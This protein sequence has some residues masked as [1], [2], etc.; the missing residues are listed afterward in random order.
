MATAERDRPAI[1][2]G[3]KQEMARVR[4]AS[5]VVARNAAW[6]LWASGTIYFIGSLAD[7]VLL[8]GYQRVPNNHQFEFTALQSTIEGLP[9]FVLALALI[10]AGVHISGRHSLLL[11]RIFAV[12]LILLGIVAGVIAPLMV[13]DYFVLRGQLQPD[14]TLM[15]KTVVLKVLTLSALHVIILVPIGVFGLRRPGS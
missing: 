5:D 11:Q 2:L 6:A 12:F 3:D 4:V 14:A 1:V 9:R 10:L 8:W 15:F 13:T 7:V